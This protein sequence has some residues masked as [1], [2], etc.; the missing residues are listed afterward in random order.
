MT[1]AHILLLAAVQGLTEFI[2]V[3][4]SGHLNLVHSVTDLA[5][6]GV[7]MDVALHAGT[8]LAVIAYFGRFTNWR[9]RHFAPPPHPKSA[10]IWLSDHRH[11]AGITGRGGVDGQRRFG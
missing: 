3:S 11:C 4:S 2:P 1:F 10:P 8:L 5:D 6:H 9:P 7:G